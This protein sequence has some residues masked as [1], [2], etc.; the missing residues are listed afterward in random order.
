MRSIAHRHPMAVFLTIAYVA[1]AAIFALPFLATTGIGV[2]DLDLPGIAP[3]VLL[4]AI[5]L[6]GAAFV[7]TAGTAFK[8]SVDGSSTSE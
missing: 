2:I 1:S 4:S 3:F 8:A 6:A 7:T 5:S